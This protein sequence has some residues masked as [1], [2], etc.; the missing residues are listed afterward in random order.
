MKIRN[1]LF[2]S[3]I[4]G[5]TFFVISC[6]NIF[7]DDASSL[8]H[9]KVQAGS[10]K[11]NFTFSLPDSG[12]K[13]RMAAPTDGEVMKVLNSLSYD[14]EFS[15]SSDGTSF[16][17]EDPVHY[18]DLDIF[19]QELAVT[20]LS[21]GYWKMDIKGQRGQNGAEIVHAS[22]IFILDSPTKLVTIQFEFSNTITGSLK[23]YVIGNNDYNLNIY[24]ALYNGDTD[25]E[26]KR[27]TLTGDNETSDSL[28]SGSMGNYISRQTF[29]VENLEPGEYYL[30]IT[31]DYNGDET[32]NYEHVYIYGGL[33][34]KG[35][36]YTNDVYA[37]LT[38]DSSDESLV[39]LYDVALDSNLASFPK[40]RKF[41]NGRITFYADDNQGNPHKVIPYKAG[42]MFTGWYTD[43]NDTQYVPGINE[44]VVQP[45]I[46]YFEP[47]DS[48]GYYIKR[49]YDL[50]AG[51]TPANY[52]IPYEELSK[53]F[54][55]EL[56][57]SDDS[58]TN[59][60]LGKSFN[61][62]PVLV[63]PYNTGT[64]QINEGY[65]KVSVFGDYITNVT[66]GDDYI[67]Y[68][69]NQYSDHNLKLRWHTLPA[70]DLITG[71]ND[72]E[73]YWIDDTNQKDLSD[74]F[75][76]V[77]DFQGYDKKIFEKLYKKGNNLYI[78]G[79][80][81]KSNSNSDPYYFCL[82]KCELDETTHTPDIG[83][84]EMFR[85]ETDD[86]IYQIQS[87][88]VSDSNLVVAYKEDIDSTDVKIASYELN[89]FGNI[90]GE[91]VLKSRSDF[92]TITPSG[93]EDFETTADITEIY[94]YDG[95]FYTFINECNVISESNAESGDSL[96]STGKV[97]KLNSNLEESSNYSVVPEIKRLDAADDV[98]LNFKG[99]STPADMN[100]FM[101]PDR[102][103]G[104]TEDGSKLFIADDGLYMYKD[105]NE[106]KA[107]WYS[108]IV[109]FDI[110][111]GSIE[112][113]IPVNLPYRG[114]QKLI[115]NFVDHF[116]Y[117]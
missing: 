58:R 73:G 108:R 80:C 7:K 53:K 91:P 28:D 86:T 68:I 44:P 104:T 34:S 27:I 2:K 9:K 103:L 55:L 65:T 69:E 37:T 87:F 96:V 62:L 24:F 74:M 111:S 45:F 11:V 115:L 110:E 41:S 99:A 117:E 29:S 70:E 6:T 54:Y 93:S 95:Y 77:E 51:W 18:S 23:Y 94:Y 48:D 32:Y 56:A 61:E 57:E 79:K 83:S 3:F 85:K 88:A 107:K 36:Y 102:I 116:S 12:K 20:T 31:E 97:L 43:A 17:T 4:I 52:V 39:H 14:V 46:P 13:A 109:V 40:I 92:Y 33:E 90:V 78:I 72:I 64:A 112:Y 98:Y 38:Y 75:T 113:Y 66:D 1:L 30:R 89:E 101:G 84:F 47:R 82:V 5:T 35:Y 59:Y 60:I 21:Y 22:E 81:Y 100:Y 16:S 67:Y 8:K 19:K 42:S 106:Y 105:S 49:N 15:Y 26:S 71:N 114:G 50:Y 10:A 25:D 76:D 63:T